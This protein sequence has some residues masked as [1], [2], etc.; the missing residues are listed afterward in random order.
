M[1]GTRLA[2]ENGGAEGDANLVT[3]ANPRADERERSEAVEAP[4]PGC[5][6]E[7]LMDWSQQ[8]GGERHCPQPLQRGTQP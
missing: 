4:V 7:P 8:F 3:N 5:E 1:R 6:R 2:D